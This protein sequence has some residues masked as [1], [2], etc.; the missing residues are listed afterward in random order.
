MIKSSPKS[1]TSTFEELAVIFD[2]WLNDWRPI[3]NSLK[4]EEYFG[5]GYGVKRSLQKLHKFEKVKLKNDF[6]GIY[7]FLKN[8]KPFY[9]GISKHVIERINQH[10][11][12]T[13]HFSSSLSY[14]IG[15]DEYLNRNG[16]SHTGGRE[17]LDFE[18]YAEPAKS[19]LIKCEV[20]LFRVE[21]DLD[22]YLFEVYIAMKLKTLYYNEFRTH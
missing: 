9:T 5:K 17:G 4:I 10:V 6:K 21:K 7:L 3:D 11:K 20:S 1:H 14:R 19:E 15:A 22:L 12:G 2:S 18:K 8:G 16:E 13:N